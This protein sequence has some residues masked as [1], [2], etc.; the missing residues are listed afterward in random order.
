[1]H[2]F[3]R[4][5]VCITSKLVTVQNMGWKRYYRDILLALLIVVRKHEPNTFRPDL[6][7]ERKSREINQEELD[8]EQQEARGKKPR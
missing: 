3:G 1:M 4:M 5:K 8:V 2:V 6:Q 7:E